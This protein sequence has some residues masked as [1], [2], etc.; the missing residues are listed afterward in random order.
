MLCPGR[1]PTVGELWD[2]AALLV[3]HGVSVTVLGGAKKR[4]R[5]IVALPMLTARG[6]PYTH[7]NSVGNV[8]FTVRERVL[9]RTQD[10]EWN[11]TIQPEAGAFQHPMLRRFRERVVDC[12]GRHS[13][14]LS[15]EQFCESMRGQKRAR[16]MQ[17][18][19]SLRSNPVRRRDSNP[20]V[21]IKPEKWF[22]WKAG[23]AISARDPRYNISVGV[24]LKPVEHVLYQA[25][26]QVYG[27]ATIMKGYTP[28]RRAA[29]IKGHWDSFRD[30]VAVG[31]DFSKFDQHI[32]QAALRWE[33]GFYLGMYSNDRTLQTLLSWQLRNRCYANCN[34]GRVRYETNGGRMSGD[35]NT[36][37]G[38]C[39][40]SA[41]LLWAYSQEHNIK[42]RAVVD[43]DDSVT[44]LERADLERYSR[45]IVEW[46]RVRGFI[47]TTEAPCYSISAVEF[48]QSR[49]FGGT[50][51]TMVRNPLKA[52]TQDHVWVYREG[53]QHADI[54]AATGLGGLSLFGDVPVLSAYYHALSRASPNGLRTLRRM[55]REAS[56]LREAGFSGKRTEV[57]EDS[58]YAFW[59]SWGITPGEQRAMEA[60]FDGCD[61]RDIA[62]RPRSSDHSNI[63]TQVY[64]PSLQSY[65]H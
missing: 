58:R 47:L 4:P 38:N 6:V 11:P 18:L 30:P 23:R 44:F 39:L 29:V 8:V 52:V 60:F 34:D 32:S 22:E 55:D 28:E 50:R 46:M 56:W 43:G 49:Y 15:P 26:D 27:S 24:F 2:T 31:Q 21:F 45:G 64:F 63:T 25:V 53:V 42:I 19:E 14:P 65:W 48:C 51:P 35:M 10:G 20:S 36:A 12:A 5:Q 3:D 33:H 9:G 17:A 13:L 62:N 57:T 37:M 40:I 7:T 61:L 41:G 59:E 54:L 1:E 16:Y